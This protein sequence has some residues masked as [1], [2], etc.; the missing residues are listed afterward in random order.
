MSTPASCAIRDASPAFRFLP[1]VY[2]NRDDLSLPRFGVDR[3]TSTDAPERPAVRL[4]EPAHF[5][6]GDR[7]QTA[8]SRI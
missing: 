7:F 6:P 1:P 8:T 5:R 4:N 3:M 2:G